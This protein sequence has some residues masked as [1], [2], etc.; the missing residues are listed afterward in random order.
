MGLVMFGDAVD[1]V[2]WPGREVRMMEIWIVTN[3]IAVAL[4][5]LRGIQNHRRERDFWRAYDDRRRS[6]NLA[7]GPCAGEQGS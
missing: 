5:G 6:E 1:G 3:V 2:D 4:A 7:V